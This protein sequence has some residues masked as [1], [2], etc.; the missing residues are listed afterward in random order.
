M[1]FLREFGVR[2]AR[3]GGQARSRL[4]PKR[5]G[6]RGLNDPSLSVP[7]SVSPQQ[8]PAASPP[9]SRF[10][11]IRFL[12]PLRAFVLSYC[13]CCCF[14]RKQMYFALFLLPSRSFPYPPSFSVFSP[15]SSFDSFPFVRVA[16]SS[17]SAS[18]PGSSSSIRTSI[19]AQVRSG[20]YRCNA[21]ANTTGHT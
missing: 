18:S 21:D 13:L 7:L 20:G 5:I 17:F 3:K 1:R 9:V 15:L 6:P 10:T 8:P 14:L 19:F 16:F 4:Q 11:A 2:A 12:P